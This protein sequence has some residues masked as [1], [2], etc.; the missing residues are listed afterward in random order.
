[1]PNNKTLFLRDRARVIARRTGFKI[2]DIEDIL[3]MDG[4]TVS[5]AIAQ[6]YSVKNHKWWKLKVDEK[7]EKRAWNGFGGTYFKQ[8]RKY[9][10]KFVPLTLLDE[11]I[12]ECNKRLLTEEEEQ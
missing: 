9:V 8:P 4:E 10:V 6:G 2:D 3:R 7:K 1:M 5:Q 12:Q 11:A